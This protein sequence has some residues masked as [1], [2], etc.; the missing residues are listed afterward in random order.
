MTLVR[1]LDNMIK[2]V[3]VKASDQIL[4]VVT[5]RIR[6]STT[7]ANILPI[8]PIVAIGSPMITFAT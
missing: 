1:Y 5:G 4:V 8:I 7:N 2:P 6:S 3:M